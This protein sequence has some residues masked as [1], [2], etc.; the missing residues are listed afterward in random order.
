MEFG[1]NLASPVAEQEQLPVNRAA[2]S[3]NHGIDGERY[4]DYPGTIAFDESFEWY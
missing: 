1:A 2:N 4:C 3:S